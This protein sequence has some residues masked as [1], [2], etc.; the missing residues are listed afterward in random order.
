MSG[1]VELLEE[2]RKVETDHAKALRPT[3]KAVSNRLASVL[4]ESILHDSRKHAAF[5]RVLIDI[6]SKLVPPETDVGDAIDTL[7]AVEEHIQ[8]EAEM[9]KRLETML[10]MPLDNRTRSVLNQMLSDERRHHEALKEIA[11]LLRQ[12]ATRFDEY[13]DLFE[14]YTY[15]GPDHGHRAHLF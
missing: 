13:L 14:K 10:K 3:M 5:C 12:G 9:M 1:L 2:Q 8:A 4:L 11:G 7:Q 6:E 15:P